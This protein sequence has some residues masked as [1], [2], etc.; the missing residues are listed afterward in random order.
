MIKRIN[1]QDKIKHNKRSYKNKASKNCNNVLSIIK[2]NN[3]ININLYY[4]DISSKSLSFFKKDLCTKYIE[5]SICLENNINN[6]NNIC[7]TSNL[8]KRNLH[9]DKKLDFSFDKDDDNAIFYNKYDNQN[10]YQNILC[11]NISSIFTFSDNHSINNYKYSNFNNID[12]NTNTNKLNNK[13][14]LD[15]IT[16]NYI[17]NRDKIVNIVKKSI[18]NDL[19]LIKNLKNI[20]ISKYVSK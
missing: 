8:L 12:K 1:K 4:T 2:S 17:F 5:N 13:N 18:E 7:N 11:D 15:K 20:N 9:L 3:I 14:A 16:N 6:V 10:N 19:N